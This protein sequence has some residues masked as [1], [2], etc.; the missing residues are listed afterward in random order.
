MPS[1]AWQVSRGVLYLCGDRQT[2]VAPTV[3]CAATHNEDYEASRL[4]L[5]ERIKAVPNAVWREETTGETTV[6][7]WLRLRRLQTP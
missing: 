7:T 6:G 4:W 2:V 5:R 3:I 1:E